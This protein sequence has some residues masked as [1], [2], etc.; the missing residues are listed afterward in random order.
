[1]LIFGPVDCAIEPVSCSLETRV[2]RHA[3]GAATARAELRATRV[4]GTAT[5]ALLAL[6]ARLAAILRGRREPIAAQLR[7]AWW[8]EMLDGRRRLAAR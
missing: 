8:R 7:L 5:L 6:D 1:L 2:D 4:R 3:S